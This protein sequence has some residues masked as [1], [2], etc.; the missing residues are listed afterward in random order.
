MRAQAGFPHLE[1]R[2][3]ETQWS[4]QDRAEGCAR[5][6]FTPHCSN[7]HGTG[8][9]LFAVAGRSLARRC[10]CFAFDRIVKLKEQ[11]YIPHQ[12]QHCTFDTFRPGTSSQFRALMEA[13]RF[14]E[15]FPMVSRG[16]F[17]TGET[18]SGKTHL[19]VAILRGAVPQI[20]RRY[21]VR[22]F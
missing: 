16:L 21:L 2:R 13:R 9:E 10:S 14:A 20:P 15:R 11:V 22:E 7:C 3:L 5:V 19:A 18:M 4:P 8:W 12:Y 6:F 17:F 1:I